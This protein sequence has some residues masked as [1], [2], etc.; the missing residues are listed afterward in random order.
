MKSMRYLAGLSV[1]YLSLTKIALA[2]S[3][4]NFRNVFIG[5]TGGTPL[6]GNTLIDLLQN[7]GGFLIV[8]GTVIAGIAIVWSG[9]VY[10]SSGNNSARVT[11]AK[12]IFKNGLIGA[13][14]V[15]GVGVIMQT[16]VALMSDPTGFFG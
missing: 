15:F 9:V 13:L 5:S 4:F 10:M 8:A 2:Q 16:L 11:S 12:A 14:I 3:N 6:S 1:A 7:T